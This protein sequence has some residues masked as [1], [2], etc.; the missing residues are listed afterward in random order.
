MHASRAEAWEGGV[1]RLIG[2]PRHSRNEDG[3]PNGCTERA[4]H[5]CPCEGSL[6][7]QREERWLHLCQAIGPSLITHVAVQGY[8]VHAWPFSGHDNKPLYRAS[9][10]VEL[11]G[12]V[13]A[14]PDT[15]RID[16]TSVARTLL[17][18]RFLTPDYTFYYFPKRLSLNKERM[19]H[20]PG[21][22]ALTTFNYIIIILLLL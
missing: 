9:H 13:G 22:V 21:G 15:G 11:R 19:L 12:W 17:G 5:L 18:N 4:H 3:V 14:A 2:A 7:A 1:C 10:T 16:N 20:R 8:C 6:I